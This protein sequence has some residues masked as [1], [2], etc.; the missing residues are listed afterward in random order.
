MEKDLTD[1]TPQ[2]AY[3]FCHQS[4]ETSNEVIALTKADMANSPSDEEFTSL[5][6]RLDKWL[7]ALNHYES[8]ARSIEQNGKVPQ[9]MVQIVFNGFGKS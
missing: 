1:M 8:V 9:K 2:E 5:R 6:E 7:D 3:A 4:I